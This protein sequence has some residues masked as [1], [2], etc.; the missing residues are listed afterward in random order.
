MRDLRYNEVLI[1][2]LFLVAIFLGAFIWWLHRNCVQVVQA[3]A[4][5]IELGR[6]AE[7][8]AARGKYGAGTTQVKGVQGGV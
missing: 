8:V 3:E 7:E 5:H 4:V 1:L 2:S 6:R